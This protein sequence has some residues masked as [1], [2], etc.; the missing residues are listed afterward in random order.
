VTLT[1]QGE[2]HANAR[3]GREDGLGYRVQGADEVPGE[4]SIESAEHGSGGNQVGDSMNI[5]L[6]EGFAFFRWHSIRWRYICACNYAVRPY[7]YDSW[8]DN[9]R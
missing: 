4:V 1:Q 2:V 9:D 8:E 6:G 7:C 3:A 5:Q